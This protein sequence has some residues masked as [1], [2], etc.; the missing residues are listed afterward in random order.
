MNAAA[1]R[2]GRSLCLGAIL[3]VIHGLYDLVAG[4]ATDWPLTTFLALNAALSLTGLWYLL[5]R[6]SPW[7]SYWLPRM[8]SEL[9]HWLFDLFWIYIVAF[10]G[11]LLAPYLTP[12]LVYTPP[13]VAT[14]LLANRLRRD[15]CPATEPLRFWL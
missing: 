10:L 8:V 14:I 3:A 4:R 13:F 12:V 11:V 5:S 2:I 15:R 6:R 7:C 9:G 1:R